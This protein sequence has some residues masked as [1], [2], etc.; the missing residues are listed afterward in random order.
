MRIVIFVKKCAIT[1]TIKVLVI[2]PLID[3]ID[4]KEFFTVR[5]TRLFDKFLLNNLLTIKVFGL[6]EGNFILSLQISIDKE[7]FRGLNF[8]FVISNRL[9]PKNLINRQKPI[10]RILNIRNGLNRKQIQFLIIA[11]QILFLL[12]IW[13]LS[14]CD[15]RIVKGTEEWFCQKLLW[16]L[17]DVG[18]LEGGAWLWLE[19]LGLDYVG[20]FA[21]WDHGVGCLHWLLYI[22]VLELFGL[23]IHHLL[24]FYYYHLLFFYYYHLLFF[25][26]LPLDF[27]LMIL[28]LIMLTHFEGDF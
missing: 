1:I 2:Y 3:R 28:A 23:L 16:L 26:Y 19:G 9:C 27:D 18:G 22:L 24:F 12:L 4:V 20:E 7:R 21:G 5:I 17:L 10:L 6:K 11:R 13:L 14:L 15:E 8:P 25:Y